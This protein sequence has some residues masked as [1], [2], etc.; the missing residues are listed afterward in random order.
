MDAPMEKQCNLCPPAGQDRGEPSALSLAAG[1]D[2]A[3]KRLDLFL[4]QN[5][6]EYGISR[7]R[8]KQLIK[9]GKV[10]LAKIPGQA[11]S[12][13]LS[14]KERLEAGAVILV[15]IPETT[16]RL[17]PESGHLDILYEDD[18]LAVIN[19]PAG[20]TVHPCPSCPEQTLAHRL[21][22][23]FSALR[24]VDGFRP[25]IVH[26]LDKDTSGLMLAAL[27]ERS[28]L[29]LAEMFA[30]RSVHKEYLTL[31]HGVPKPE[32]GTIAEPVGRH[33]TLKTK[34]AVVKNGKPAQSAWR[35]LYADPKGRFALLAVRIFTG[36]THQIRVHMA[37]MGHPLW[38]DRVYGPSRKEESLP[39]PRQMLH[40]WKLSFVH[41]FLPAPE[42]FP[43]LCTGFACPPPEDFQQTFLALARSMQRIVITGLPG[44][45]KSAVARILNDCGLP[46]FS[47][48]EEVKKLYEPG[49]HVWFALSSR[50]GNKFVPSPASPVDKA[51]LGAAMRE[52]PAFRKE[53]EAL[54]H[55]L[56]KH[57]LDAFWAEQERKGAEAAVAEIPLF[58]EARFP[59]DNDPWFILVGVA[60]PFEARSRRLAR[61]RNWSE[62][63]IAAMEA[64]QWPEKEKMNACDYVLTNDGA[65]K[66]LAGKTAGLLG[67]LRERKE[68]EEKR[69]AGLFNRLWQEGT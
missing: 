24:A 43:P 17:T 50:Y 53:I 64:W 15:D 52:S 32:S 40:A 58:A 49:G 30:Q 62:E 34:M 11:P 48:D 25:G 59:R 69:L 2:D 1:R 33:P 63:A 65:K 29:A 3:G 66:D 13:A 61:D 31:V 26:R 7:E 57:A 19:K 27:T 8:A 9:D 10:R 41:P 21:V 44:S 54:V 35:T 67:Y 55:P 23:R 45:G 20:L 36:R 68:A 28:R 47:A 4:G 56:V 18:W 37:H 38:G 22:A 39:A 5:L 14:P 60:A 16:S 46:L 6:A 12:A 42:G 51:A